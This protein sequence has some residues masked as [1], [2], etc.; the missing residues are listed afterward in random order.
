MLGLGAALALPGCA[1]HSSLKDAPPVTL[2]GTRQL[3]LRAPG[4]PGPG[5]PERVHRI[6]VACRPRH[7][8]PRA[9]RCSICL[10]ATCCSRPPRS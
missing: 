7:H 9:T 6:M 8:R 1:W 5:A 4:M 10:T 3:D 2:P